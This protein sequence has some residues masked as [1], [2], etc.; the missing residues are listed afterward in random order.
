MSN[1]HVAHRVPSGSHRAL[2]LLLLAILLQ[3]L[4]G[5]IT[6]KAI[7]E[8]PTVPP[9]EKINWA[10]HVRELT[11]LSDWQLEGKIGIKQKD[12]GG[13]AYINW[14]QSG[15]SFHI[16]L[17]GPLGA[18]TTIISGNDNGAKLESASDGSFIAE[19]PEELLYTHTG[20]YIPLHNLLYWVKGL[21]EPRTPADTTYTARGYIS[22]LNQGPWQLKFERY[23]RDLGVTLPH[24]VKM[25]TQDL[26]VT[27]VIKDWN[28]LSGE[29]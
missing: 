6:H 7:Q 27:L 12:D 19:S 2:P 28:S 16:T 4:A 14:T 1:L 26:K 10:D 22:S 21:P 15:D 18:G 20:W 25:E 3:L 8:P 5:C 13:S 11:L 9:I 17:S 23:K 29:E 24:K